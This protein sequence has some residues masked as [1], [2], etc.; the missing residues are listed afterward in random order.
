MTAP[1][2]FAVTPRGGAQPLG[3]GPALVAREMTTPDRF[4][5]TPR[6]GVQPLGS[7]PALVARKLALL[8]R[9]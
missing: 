7:G 9:I 1:D 2:R 3:S 6:G 8:R 4:A 5:V